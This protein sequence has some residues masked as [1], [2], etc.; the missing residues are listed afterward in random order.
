MKYLF[1]R[2][3]EGISHQITSLGALRVCSVLDTFCNSPCLFVE[4]LASYSS[5]SYSRTLVSFYFSFFLRNI[6]FSNKLNSSN[7]KKDSLKILLKNFYICKIDK[8][9]KLFA[10]S[11]RSE[12]KRNYFRQY[13]HAMCGN[14]CDSSR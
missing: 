3:T 11:I 8:K 9:S 12:E 7:T 4:M 13:Y 10:N 5:C 14:I 2:Y 6:F 1:Q